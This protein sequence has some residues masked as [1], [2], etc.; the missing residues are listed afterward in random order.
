MTTSTPC[1]DCQQQVT[2]GRR[3]GP[4]SHLRLVDSHA[5]RG[6]MFGGSEEAT[7]QCGVCGALITHT[8]DKNDFAP[9]WWFV[10]A[11]PKR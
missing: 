9:F 1:H 5:F 2:K 7:Y 10:D 4:H 3:D 11:V 6:S 8:N